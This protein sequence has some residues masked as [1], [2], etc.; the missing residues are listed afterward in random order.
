[1]SDFLPD[2]VGACFA[3]LCVFV[4]KQNLVPPALIPRFTIGA[5]GGY[6]GVTVELGTDF[7]NAELLSYG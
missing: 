3:I 4:A 2:S 7:L 6:A 1:V 5:W